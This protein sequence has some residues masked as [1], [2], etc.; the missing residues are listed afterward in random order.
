M[1]HEARHLLGR[2]LSHTV[3][4][5]PMAADVAKFP[6]FLGIGEKMALLEAVQKACKGK[7]NRSAAM[8][9]K[10]N[11]LQLQVRGGGEAGGDWRAGCA[12]LWAAFRAG[13]VAGGPGV[14]GG[15]RRPYGPRV[16]DLLR[17]VRNL[18][19]HLDE[20]PVPVRTLL[21]QHAPK[22]LAAG[23]APGAERLQRRMVA[24]LGGY[25]MEVS[26]PNL[27]VELWG[28]GR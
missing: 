12:D 16:C 3:A 4:T 25:F 7:G 23:A 20:L 21:L 18:R 27:A 6:L 22:A 28:V 26:F 10:V 19:E 2:M 8:R 11:L 5:R 13:G 17:M 1:A 24:A 14:T 9:S 15:D